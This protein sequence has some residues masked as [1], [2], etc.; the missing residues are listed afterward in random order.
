MGC[1][2]QYSTQPGWQRVQAAESTSTGELHDHHL[3]GDRLGKSL[4]VEP[5]RGL[6][7][8]EFGGLGFSVPGHLLKKD[9]WSYQGFKNEQE[10]EN[11][12]Q[13]LI[14]RIAKLRQGFSAAVY[15]QLTDVETEINGLLTHD[16]K[17]I[18]VAPNRL[19]EIHRKLYEVPVGK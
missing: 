15:T 8:G 7:L 18:K 17:V 9:A 6:V 10:R 14:D 4:P 13:K 2:P 19:R 1:S 12:Y 3:Y 5:N 11:A 16:R